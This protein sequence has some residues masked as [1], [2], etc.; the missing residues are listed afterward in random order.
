MGN[1]QRER[2]WWFVGRVLFCL[3]YLAYS[4]LVLI[5]VSRVL[6]D[7][8]AMF[9]IAATS[10]PL[11]PGSVGFAIV[12]LLHIAASLTLLIAPAVAAIKFRWPTAA[13]LTVSYLFAAGLCELNPLVI[14]ELWGSACG[15]C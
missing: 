12:I 5:T 9:L 4:G 7:I 10:T 13:V 8:F 14:C 2:L 3:A 6:L 11:D 15:N 1:N